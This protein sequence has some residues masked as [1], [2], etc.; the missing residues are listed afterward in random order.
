MAASRWKVYD[1]AKEKLG[2]STID[3]DGHTFKCALFATGSNANDL[4]NEEL[5]DLTNEVASAFGYTTGGFTLTNVTWTNNSGVITFTT[6][7][8]IQ[9]LASGG[10]IVARYAVIYDDTAANDP[11]LCICQLDIGSSVTALNGDFLT[12]QQSATGIL[13]LSGGTSN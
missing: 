1:T 3:L 11:L 5:A 6:A 12:I 9:W 2:D 13:T 8:D 10:S 7:D 4:T